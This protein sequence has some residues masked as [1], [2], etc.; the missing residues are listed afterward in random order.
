M[1]TNTRC[2]SM[3]HPLAR[4]TLVACATTFGGTNFNSNNF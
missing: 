4:M 2:C 1:I 3:S